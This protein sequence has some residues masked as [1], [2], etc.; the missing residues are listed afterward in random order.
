MKHW[1]RSAL[2]LLAGSTLVA[3]G[4]DEAAEEAPQVVVAE[5]PAGGMEGMP[6]MQ[7]MQMGGGMI[8]QM[9]AH[10]QTMQGETG[11]QFKANLPQHRQMVANMIAQMNGEMRDMNMAADS[12][13]NQTVEALREDL[14][15]LPEMS[16]SELESFMPE[17]RQR[18]TRL[19]EMHRSMMGNMQ[20]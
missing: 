17:H 10:M 19:M 16:A 18:I 12:E 4:G 8:E 14:K 11:A 1:T 20:M 13:W 15:R 5:Q 7:G 6:G 3:C 9:Q 2:A